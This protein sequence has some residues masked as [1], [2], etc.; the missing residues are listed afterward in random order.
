V[1]LAVALWSLLQQVLDIVSPDLDSNL[2][3]GSSSW[4]LLWVRGCSSGARDFGGGSDRLA[5]GAET[6]QS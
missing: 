3:T 1:I 6:P 2:K 5:D 4:D